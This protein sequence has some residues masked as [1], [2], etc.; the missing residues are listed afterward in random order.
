MQKY[1]LM[2]SSALLV[3]ALVVL[4]G[5][6]LFKPASCPSCKP[7]E[8]PVVDPADLLLSIGGKP[9]VTKQQFEEFYELAA[10]NA[11]PYGGPSKRDVFKQLEAMAILDHQIS[12]SGKDQTAEYKKDLARAY[13]HAR[14]TINTQTIAKELQGEI[15]V[16]DSALSKFYTE[17]IGKNQAFD[18]PPFLKNTESIRIQAVEFADKAAAEEFLKKAKVNFAGEAVA[19]GLSINDLGAVSAQSEEVDFAIRIKAK[20]LKPGVVELVQSSDKTYVIKAGDKVEKQ[21]ATFSEIKAM[22][23]IFEKFVDFKKQNELEPAF[24]E[25]IEKYKKGL[26][27]VSNDEYFTADDEQRKTEQE[28][29]MKMFEQ[30]MKAQQ[31]GE[32]PAAV[33]AA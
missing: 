3:S 32:Q 20:S 16:S 4:T 18:Q 30:Q 7:A 2:I 9:A 23:D 6:D 8:E 17:Q 25:R 26:T 11:G 33:V 1:R 13:E 5:C 29:L 21:Y 27:L 31:E 12:S 10:A 24:M 14:W 22:P 19:G 28:Q 15:D